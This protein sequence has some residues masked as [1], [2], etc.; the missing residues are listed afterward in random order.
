ML[1]T[2]WDKHLKGL[3]KQV[4]D[5]VAKLVVSALEIYNKF[6]SPIA[7][8]LIKTLGPVFTKIFGVV[9]TVV[10]KTVGAIADTAKGIFKA[11]GGV[12]D[13]VT[14]VFTGNWRK[15]WNGVK[16]IFGGVFSSLY[17]LVKTPMN[18]IIDMINTVI[19]G[20]NNIS[21]KIPKWSP[22]GAG[23]TFGINIAKIPRLAK[24]GIT[25]GPTMAMI[26]DNPGGQEVV[27]PLSDLKD[28]IGS[29]VGT[30]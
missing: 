22:I 4:L 19:G 11:L 5:F 27:S 26:G 23:E 28:M 1:T 14:G 7:N 13:F 10:G 21:I 12:I 15:A 25:N 6:I 3:V 29:A 2:L 17:S 9:M 18:W 16:D 24:G 8:Y 20:L 30:A